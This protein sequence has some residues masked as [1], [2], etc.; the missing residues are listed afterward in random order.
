[1]LEPGC[2]PRFPLYAPGRA[3]DFCW[4]AFGILVVN[5]RFVRLF[6]RLDV[7]DV[8]FIPAEVDGHTGP[9]FIL[10]PL[11]VIRCIDDA[12]CEE[13]RYFQPEDGQPE[14]VGEYRV[15]SEEHTSE[16]QS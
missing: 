12:R 3:L 7:R 1:M 5:G 13:V 8:Q 4:A 6:E 16:L 14:K 9:Y 10:N 11:R 2:V 15:R